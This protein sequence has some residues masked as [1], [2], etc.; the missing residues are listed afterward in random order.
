MISEI[1]LQIKFTR[2][3]FLPNLIPQTKKNIHSRKSF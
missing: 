2:L 1:L 3:G